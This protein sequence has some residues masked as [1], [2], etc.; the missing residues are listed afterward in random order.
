[1]NHKV[2]GTSFF[3]MWEVG[4]P[5]SYLPFPLCGFFSFD[6]HA[7]FVRS[8]VLCECFCLEFKD[9]TFRRVYFFASQLLFGGK[10]GGQL[11]NTL[12]SN[13]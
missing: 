6:V 13:C 11:F 12:S 7:I 2:E 9:P 8:K 3:Q 10:K 5:Q 1:M 4:G